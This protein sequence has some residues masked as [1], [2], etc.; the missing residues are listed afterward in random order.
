M[1]VVYILHMS[2]VGKKTS[3]D[4]AVRSDYK[5]KLVKSSFYNEQATK[6]ALCAFIMKAEQFSIG[7]QCAQFEKKFCEWQER[8]YT[9]LFNTGS[10]ANLALIQALLNLGRLK[11]GMKVGFS[12]VTWATN[13]M[14]LMQL[15][16]NSI[17][18]DV[19]LETL[20]CSLRTLQEAHT[21][22]KLDAF[23]LTNLLGFADNISK[24][25]KYCSS[26]GILLI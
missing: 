1:G 24:I 8:R 22:Y 13:V 26:Q 14:P 11:P 7:A 18:V 4:S 3:T 16:L 25:K 10:S 5:I 23:F 6:K 19:E 15:G 9:S 12:G 20:N 17:P 2:S 21:K